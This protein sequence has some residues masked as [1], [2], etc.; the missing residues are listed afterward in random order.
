MIFDY[1]DQYI[2]VHFIMFSD[3]IG[4]HDVIRNIQE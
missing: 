2:V 3:A 1:S 4:I